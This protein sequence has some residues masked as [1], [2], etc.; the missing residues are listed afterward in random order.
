MNKDLVVE[1]ESLKKDYLE[2]ERI[3]AHEKACL[4][5]VI[6]T[7]GMLVDENPGYH[8]EYRALKNLLNNENKLL[9]DQINES[10]RE[11]RSKAFSSEAKKDPGE[12]T[13]EQFKSLKESLVEAC[14]TLR[15][16]MFALLDDFYPLSDDMKAKVGTFDIKY[17]EEIDRDEF[18]RMSKAILDY[19]KGLK[20][21]ISEDFRYINSTFFMLLDQVKELESALADEFGDDARIKE[22]EQFETKVHREVGSIV[23]SFS[24]YETIN[25]IKSAVVSKIANVKR[26]LIKKKKDE[27]QKA[28]R[29][30]EN[31]SKLKKRI[32]QAEKGAREMS[33]KAKRFQMIAKRDGLTGLYNRKAFDARLEEAIQ[34]YNKNGEPFSLVIFDLDRFKWINDSFGH[35]AGDK[36]LMKVAESLNEIFRKTD[37]ISRYGGD[38]FA[39]VI[40]GLNEQMAHE[41]IMI[42][43]ENFGKKRFFSH[44]DGDIKVSI[45]SGVAMV[46]QGDSVQ[47][48]IHRADKA[49]YDSKKSKN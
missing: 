46:N 29:A 41:R 21:K 30:Q 14:M 16:V 1:L 48:I 47:D 5:G 19:I 13:S 9:I 8:E 11:L 37:F 36:V 44:K 7:L 31:I 18:K 39:V 49:M 33:K 27:V 45:S 26:L 32:V 28:Q 38:E 25:E 6:N 43:Q 24:V 40:E 3:S 35:V 20:G 10:V 4:M 17:H 23:N 12:V 34:T 15:G 42:F 2:V 22:F